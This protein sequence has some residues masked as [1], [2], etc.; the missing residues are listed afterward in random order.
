[1]ETI[2]GKSIADIF[3]HNNNWDNFLLEYGGN[4]NV[5]I[6]PAIIDN[7]NKI[8]ACRKKELGYRTYKCSDCEI[9][10]MVKFSCKSRF[11]CS[12]GKKGTDICVENGFA[13]L[14]DSVWQHITFTLPSCY[15]DLFWLNRDL[16]GVVP[17]IAIR[18]C[19]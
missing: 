9:V 11:C 18:K 14:P 1:M 19:S 3:I 4:R 16:Q 8:I 15:W 2:T 7:V 17:R 12:C 13:R 5:R 6:R 10:K